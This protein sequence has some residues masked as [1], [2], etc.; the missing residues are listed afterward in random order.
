MSENIQAEVDNELLKRGR[1]AL[2]DALGAA[3]AMEFLRVKDDVVRD[4]K[5]SDGIKRIMT[6][7]YGDD[8]SG[9]VVLEFSQSITWIR[10]KQ[11]DALTFI[12]Q[13]K[14]VIG[15]LNGKAQ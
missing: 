11:S 10:F 7:I 9:E 14:G 13:I 4:E 2:V 6:K 15:E 12:E 3:G 1:A 8:S 5:D